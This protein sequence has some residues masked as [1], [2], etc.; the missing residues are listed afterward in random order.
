MFKRPDSADNYRH[1]GSLVRAVLDAIDIVWTTNKI[2]GL[3]NAGPF[4]FIDYA[5]I[6]QQLCNKAALQ[7]Q[8]AYLELIVMFC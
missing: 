7:L 1:R 8:E 6:M 3:R 4:L 5:T 2:K